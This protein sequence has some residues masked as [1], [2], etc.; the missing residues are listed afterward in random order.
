[1]AATGGTT[2]L[3]W[4]VYATGIMVNSKNQYIGPSKRCK[5]A[6]FWLQTDAELY[7]D[8]LRKAHAN[9]TVEIVDKN[10]Y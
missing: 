5:M 4:W 6:A 9:W 3:N 2:G 10:K 7:V 8:S 1:M